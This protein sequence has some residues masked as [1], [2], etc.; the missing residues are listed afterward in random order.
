[1]G[2]MASGPNLLMVVDEQT[3]SHIHYAQRTQEHGYVA[4][5]VSSLDA[6]KDAYLRSR[7][8]L[9]AVNV[10][11][12]GEDCGDVLDFLARCRCLAPVVLTT[13]NSMRTM[14]RM[15][16]RMRGTGLRIVARIRKDD[17]LFALG[18]VLRVHRRAGS[19][20]SLAR[21]VGQARQ[22]FTAP[23]R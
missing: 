8:S 6:F 18:E 11:I 22:D 7:P 10:M 3:G 9:I 1:M 13:R 4:V 21:D 15:E 16:A 2:G 20:A 5:L 23:G 12:G 17:D 14:E 19:G